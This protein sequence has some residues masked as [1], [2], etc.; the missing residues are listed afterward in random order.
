MG[1]CEE[2]ENAEAV[3]IKCL[4]EKQNIQVRAE[5]DTIGT[6]Y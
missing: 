3:T 5:M 2:E 6:K 1:K 4:Q